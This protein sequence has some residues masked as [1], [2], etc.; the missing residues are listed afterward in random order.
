MIIQGRRKPSVNAAGAQDF[1]VFLNALQV[2]IGL[3]DPPT[4]AAEPQPQSLFEGDHAVFTCLPAGTSPI[5]VQWYHGMNP[6]ENPIEE[7]IDTNTTLVIFF[8]SA[9][10]AGGYS[11]IATSPYGSATSQVAMLTVTPVGNLA[12]GLVAHWPLDTL[13]SSTPD[14][15][16]NMNDLF[17]ANMDAINVEEG[18]FISALRFNGADEYVARTNNGTTGLPLYGSPAYSVA[19]W[20]NGNGTGQNDRR[21]WSESADTNNSPLMT[22]GTHSA[23]T[24]GTVDIFLRGNSGANPI[25][26]RRTSLIAFDGSWHHIAW[27][28]NNGSGRVYVDGVLDTNNFNYAR[29]PLQGNIIS[30]GAVVRTNVVA[31]YNG[32]IDDVHARRRALSEEEVRV[33]MDQPPPIPPPSI[34]S[35]SG[36]TLPSVS[37]AR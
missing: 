31:Q 17:Q 7:P 13:G 36:A 5:S 28:D 35:R 15:T 23:G 1:G 33:V 32:L 25:N 18:R 10:N 14:V 34:A 37:G 26:H 11:M 6:G 30:L 12:S 2:E 3:P 22:I 27:V 8:A 19:M 24:D 4:I 29:V 16:P 9:G 20:V 21:V